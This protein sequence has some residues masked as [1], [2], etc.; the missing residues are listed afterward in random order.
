MASQLLN[1]AR[2]AGLV[3]G[4]PVAVAHDLNQ[5]G[6]ALTPDF[7]APTL[8]GFTVAVDATNVTVTRTVDAPGGAVDVWVEFKH[9]LLREFGSITPSPG[10]QPEGSLVPSPLILV[11]GTTSAIAVAGRYALPEKW[12]QDNV[13]AAQ[14]NVD[15]SAR[16]STLFD[17]IKVIR[18][19]SLLGMS[20]RLNEAITAGTL[21]V[22]VEINGVATTLLLAHT[23]GVN[24]TG[25]EVTIAAG[26]DPLVAGDLVGITIVTTAGFLPVTTDLECWLDIDT[27]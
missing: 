12:G 2:F 23:A 19:G 3:V 21:T 17:T 1:I 14:V 26:V 15:L 9:T 8:G 24:P 11:P 7:V 13:A 27:D 4:V 25:G 16:V 20:T 22:T 10:N 6:R 18:A 5:D